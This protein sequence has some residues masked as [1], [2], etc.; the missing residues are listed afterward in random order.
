[1]V[2]DGWNSGIMRI[3]TANDEWRCCA[4]FEVEDNIKGGSCSS[5]NSLSSVAFLHILKYLDFTFTYFLS[6][7]LSVYY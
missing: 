7:F 5:S 1:M 3:L 4:V 2:D 6:R